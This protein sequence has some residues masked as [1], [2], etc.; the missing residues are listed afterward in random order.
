[1]N[2]GQWLLCQTVSTL[3]RQ[4][5]KRRRCNVYHNYPKFIIII[6]DFIEKIDIKDI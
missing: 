2:S 5:T 4:V 6:I 1:M 3:Q